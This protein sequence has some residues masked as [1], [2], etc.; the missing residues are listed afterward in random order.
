MPRFTSV[1]ARPR[2]WRSTRSLPAAQSADRDMEPTQV[3]ACLPKTYRK[4]EKEAA[5]LPRRLLHSGRDDPPGT[6]QPAALA[7]SHAD[8]DSTYLA[9]A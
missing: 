9:G 1:F 7:R 8:V 6:L 2:Q 4:Y 5:G 3:I